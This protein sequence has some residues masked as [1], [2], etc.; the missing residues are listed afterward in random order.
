[1][2]RRRYFVD[3]KFQW[4]VIAYTFLIS[5][6]T[7]L[8]HFVVEHWQALENSDLTLG[9]FQSGTRIAIG[10]FY[11]VFYAC[12][13]CVAILF[14]N[15]LAGPLFRLRKHMSE[16]ASRK[17]VS[18]MFFRKYDYYS[19]LNETYNRLIESLPPE[20]QGKQ[21]QS[22]FT[23]PELVVALA[24]IGL[25]VGITATSTFGGA[26]NSLTYRNE[27]TYL[28]DLLNT[29]RNAAL[30][31][32]ECAIVTVVSPTQVTLSTY[33]MA[34]PCTGSLP[35]PDLVTSHTFL[36]STV[37]SAFSTNAPLI[38]QPGGST[39]ATGPVTISLTS[40]G[41]TNNF[42]VYPAIGQVRRQ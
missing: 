32:N 36:A 25:L 39:T 14:S 5:L 9:L 19:E 2:N 7:T 10:V 30:I 40:G 1:M 31:K 15:R 6:L 21:G 11:F 42:T 20:R 41:R 29:G 18:P 12:I 13:L 3:H 8:I 37:V 34:A 22:G 27:G 4:T 35:S 26:Q 16:A 33:P 23:L 38:F 24:I 17:P 28:Q